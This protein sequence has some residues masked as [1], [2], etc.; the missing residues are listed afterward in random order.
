MAVQ[1]RASSGGKARAAALTPEERSESARKAVRARWA[2]PSVTVTVITGAQLAA[3]DHW[4]NDAW[5]V[6]LRCYYRISVVFVLPLA[7]QTEPLPVT[8]TSL[9]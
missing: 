5:N 2:K 4:E 3:G 9:K 8:P 6:N 7:V 1:D